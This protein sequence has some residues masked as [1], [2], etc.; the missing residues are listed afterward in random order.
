MSPGTPDLTILILVFI[1]LQIWWIF[2]LFQKKNRL[3]QKGKGS[4]LKEKIYQLEELYRK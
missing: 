2:A 1:A 4:G 3:N